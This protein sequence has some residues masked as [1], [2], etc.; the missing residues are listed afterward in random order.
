MERRSTGAEHQEAGSLSG[1]QRPALGRTQFSSS[2]SAIVSGRRAP[3]SCVDK[4]ISNIHAPSSQPASGRASRP[5]SADILG[6]RR[7]MASR[8]GRRRRRARAASCQAERAQLRW[9]RQQQRAPPPPPTTTTKP[10]KLMAARGRPRARANWAP[11]TVCSF[12]ALMNTR[13][14]AGRLSESRGSLDRGSPAP[15]SAPPTCEPRAS[16][17]KTIMESGRAQCQPN[18]AASSAE[19]AMLNELKN[20]PLPAHE[21]SNLITELVIL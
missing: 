8:L 12:H 1:S 9:R 19:R 11:Q 10:A 2:R 16:Y 7:T 3:S 13:L 20:P 4:S 21:T 5:A 17:C 14:R 15:S 18:I 6:A